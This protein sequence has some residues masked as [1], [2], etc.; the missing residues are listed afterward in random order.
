MSE[1]AA[2]AGLVQE[3]LKQAEEVKGSEHEEV[4]ADGEEAEEEEE[5][6][7]DDAEENFI[8]NHDLIGVKGIIAAQKNEIE[9]K[10]VSVF[11]QGSLWRFKC[12][13]LTDRV[14]DFFDSLNF[15]SKMNCTSASTP[16]W[17]A[18]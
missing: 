12:N 14:C 13:W 18:W 4:H 9:K 2:A 5:E 11:L 15:A 7:E 17:W 8:N 3:E 1:A 6:E 16:S 10:K